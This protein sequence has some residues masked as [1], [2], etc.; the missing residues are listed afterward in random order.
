MQALRLSLR[1]PE[2]ARIVGS[3]ASLI[4]AALLI[5]AAAVYLGS[6]RQD[7]LQRAN[8]ERVVAHS[9]NSLQRSLTTT[10]RDYAWWS[11]AVRSLVLD[12]ERGLGRHQHRALCL[13]DLRL[14]DGARP[15]RRRPPDPGLAAQCRGRRGSCAAAL[16]DMLP[17]AA[18]RGAATAVGPEPIAVSAYPARRGQACSSRPPVRSCRSRASTGAAVGPPAMLVFAKRLDDALPR[19]AC[20]RTSA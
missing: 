10:V 6:V 9:V 3:L 11:E 7:A 2:D 4:A 18:R 15:G 1:R 17:S 20:A 13:C 8:E 12:L 5:V 16:G 14:R 19:Q